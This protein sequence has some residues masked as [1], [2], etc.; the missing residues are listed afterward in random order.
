MGGAVYSIARANH[1]YPATAFGYSF[2]ASFLWEFVLEFKEKVS[3]NDVIVTPGTAVPI[4][5]FFYKLGLYL[6]TAADPSTGA[7]IAQW[8]LGTGVAFDRALDGRPAPRVLVPDT[9]DD[10]DVPDFLK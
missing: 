2:L 5:E 6:D 8:S 3:V 10:L 1:H 4:G 9:N 7:A